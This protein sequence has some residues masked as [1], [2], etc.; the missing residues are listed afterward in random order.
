MV[1]YHLLDGAGTKVAAFFAAIAVAVVV[2][3]S[4]ALPTAPS[5]TC[6]V[7]VAPQSP[8]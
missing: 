5:C 4:A 8:Q 7:E 3:F 1:A 6:R 2:A